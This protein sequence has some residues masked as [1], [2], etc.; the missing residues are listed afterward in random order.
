MSKVCYEKVIAAL[1]LHGTEKE[2][3]EAAGIT[4]SKMRELMKE[5]SFI[6]DYTAAKNDIV[7]KAV[8]TMNEK[9]SDAVNVVAEIMN[10]QSNPA[11]LRLSAAQTI[12]NNAGKF[13]DRLSKEEERRAAQA[14]SP[15]D[16]DL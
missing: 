11:P 16:I 4:Q 10:D 6:S 14:R 8:L 12:I 9:A 2:A 1:L 5:R 13:A 3:A 7:R 15:Y